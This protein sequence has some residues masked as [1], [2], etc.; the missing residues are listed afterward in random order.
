ML[1]S[2]L[3]CIVKCIAS[4]VAWPR[5]GIIFWTAGK[6]GCGQSFELSIFSQLVV[7]GAGVWERT[8]PGFVIE[9]GMDFG[10]N[11]SLMG[12]NDPWQDKSVRLFLDVGRRKK[13]PVMGPE[14]PF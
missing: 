9:P 14:F 5:A 13:M 2:Y 10:Q 3:Q 6:M 8:I 11:A 1:D 4:C 7:S 12:M